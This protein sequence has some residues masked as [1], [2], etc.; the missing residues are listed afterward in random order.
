MQFQT[1]ITSGLAIAI[2]LLNY[3][4]E[5]S[6]INVMAFS[7]GVVFPDI[8]EPNSFIGKRTKGVSHL[9]NLF[10]GHRGITHSLFAF[11]FIGLLSYFAISLLSF[12]PTIPVVL[13]VLGYLTHLIQ[14]SFS[15]S[16][17]KWLL[18]FSSRSF[19]SGLDIIYYTTGGLAE[20]TI[21]FA[22]AVL[23]MIYINQ[24][25]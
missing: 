16:G 20:Y 22:S 25:T 14:D 7:L 8:D 6:A 17:V 21:F 18:P 19:Q 3:S 1:H 13:F 2:P 12:V 15:K 24:L 11:I 9:M 23:I 5:L 4:D 10:F